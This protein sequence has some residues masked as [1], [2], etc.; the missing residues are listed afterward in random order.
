MLVWAFKE[1]SNAKFNDYLYDLI[2]GS[3]M[4]AYISHYVFIVL[5][6][7]YIV[8]PLGLTYVQALIS[9]VLFAEVMVLITYFLIEKIYSF[10]P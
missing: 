10:M 1:H 5:S 8:R 3:S 2:V 7:N 9:N 6:A 4:W